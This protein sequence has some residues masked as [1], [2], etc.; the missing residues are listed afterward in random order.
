MLERGGTE[1][2]TLVAEFS[3]AQSGVLERGGTEEAMLIGKLFPQSSVT[4]TGVLEHEDT[5]DGTV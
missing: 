2:A 3:R 5:E 4:Q 1:K